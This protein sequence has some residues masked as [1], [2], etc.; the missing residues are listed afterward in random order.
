M[1]RW[2]GRAFWAL[3]LVIAYFVAPTQ[4]ANPEPV[5]SDFV[6]HPSIAAQPESGRWIKDLAIKGN[7]LY[8]G[9]G[10]YSGN[11]GPIDIATADLSTGATSVKATANTEEINTYRKY[12]GYLYAPW[13]DT[14]GVSGIYSSNRSGVWTDY[15]TAVE[16]EHV[17]DIAVLPNG[18]KVAV[19]SSNNLARTAYLGATAWVSYDKGQTWRVEM[20][21]LTN[22]HHT[23]VTGYERY[24]WVAVINGKAYMQARAI[25]S[26]YGQAEFPIRVFDGN[27]WSS[28]NKSA[29]CFSTY[30]H[31]VEVYNNRAYCGNG[32]VFNGKRGTSNG[33]ISATTDFYQFNG[34]LYALQG[35]KIMQ[36][37]GNQWV[38]IA[39]APNDR[40]ASIAVTDT[41]LYVGDGYGHVS[42]AHR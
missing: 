21:D 24:Y 14:K 26:I 41:Y 33:A 3:L 37:Y 22:S 1:I 30:A 16:T 10:D 36:L 40:A 23:T 13:I 8:M 34:V 27:R 7:D 28:I 35:G 17:F 11:T 15:G 5:F 25:T 32:T 4:T 6:F 20:T 9:Y 38:Q 31:E 42:R 39:T 12:N 2:V 29:D 18:V 19:G